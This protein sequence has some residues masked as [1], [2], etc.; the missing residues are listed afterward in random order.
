MG[1]DLRGSFANLTPLMEA[2]GVL[3]YV[4]C[5]NETDLVG[6]VLFLAMVAFDGNIGDIGNLQ[7]R[8]LYANSLAFLL[9]SRCH[10]DSYDT[11][12][13]LR[14]LTLQPKISGWQEFIFQVLTG[15]CI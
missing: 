7:H 15:S 12:T 1:I 3:L 8:R 11:R 13:Y 6:G 2:A 5:W 9:P 10:L 14:T 4:R